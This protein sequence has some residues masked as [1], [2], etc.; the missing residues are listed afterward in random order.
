M[1]DHD[2]QAETERQHMLRQAEELSRKRDEFPLPRAPED[3][4]ELT[5][6]SILLADLASLVQDLSAEVRVRSSDGQ[7]DPGLDAVVG[8]WARAAGHL[9]EAVG[10]Y[11]AA[12]RQ[13][14]FLHA[15]SRTTPEHAALRDGRQAAF[16]LARQH[17]ADTRDG[18]S[19]AHASMTNGAALLEG[20]E[21]S[22]V[23]RA[24]R[25]RSAQAD[26]ARD[27]AS[28]EAEA[29]AEASAQQPSHVPG[30]IRGR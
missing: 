29:P 19:S 21:A 28:A 18:L 25:A 6:A 13:L 4:P 2:H 27:Q 11:G 1:N 16:A 14:G 7:P 5:N 17:I 8:T 26:H 24:A 12:Y 23:S 10:H 30:P 20:A 9:S 15:H 22:S 3:L